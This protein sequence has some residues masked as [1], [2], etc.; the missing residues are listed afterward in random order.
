MEIL[1]NTPAGLRSILFSNKTLVKMNLTSLILAISVLQVCAAGSYAQTARLSL[2]MT[3]AR[4][5]EVLQDIE[6]QSEFFFLYSPR[7]I[8]VDRRISVKLKNQNIEEVLRKIFMDTDVE[9]V[10][11]G[12][13]IV[14]STEDLT[15]GDVTEL[16][17]A[18]AVPIRGTVRDAGGEAL[19]G[20]NIL[21]KGTGEGTVTDFDGNYQLDLETG[22][23]TLVFSYTGYQTMEVQVEGQS[24][25]DI[26]MVASIAELDEVVVVGY[27]TQRKKDLTG[28][29]GTIDGDMVAN[30]QNMQ[31]SQALQGSMA[32]VQVTRDNG[33]PGADA[34]IRIRGVTTIGDN[35]PLIIV[36]GIPF[37]NIDDVNPDDI[38][39]ISVLKDAASAAIYGSRAAAGV[40]LVT[41]KRAEA[42]QLNL[43]YNAE[44]GYDSPTDY[45]RKVDVVRYMQADNEMRWN[46]NGNT[47]TEYGTYPQEIVDNYPSLHADNPNLYPDVDMWDLVI[48]DRALRT[49]HALSLSAGTNVIRSKVSLAYDYDDGLYEKRKFER[50]SARFNND[51]TINDFISATADIFWRRSV[52]ND[53]DVNPIPHSIIHAPVYAAEWD[54][55][56]VAPGKA[57]AN[58][59]GQVKYGGFR[60][61]W[62]TSVGG[63]A[64]LTITPVEGLRFT[65]VVAPRFD[66][67]KGKHFRKKVEATSYSDPSVVEAVLQYASTTRLDEFRN[68]DLNVTTQF[69]AS[70]DKD[71]GDHHFNVMGG[72]ENFY[73][74]FEQQSASR[75]Q[76]DLNS[77]PYLNI[78]PLDL[79]DNSG[80]AWENA[81]RSWFGRI[82]YDYANKYYLQANVRFDGSSRFDSDYRWGSFPSFSAGWAISEEPFFEGFAG[83][84]FLKLRASWGTLGNERIGNYPY[85]STIDFSNAL[86]YQGSQVVSLQTAAQRQLAIRDISWETTESLDFGIDAVFFDNRVRLTADYFLKKTNDMLLALEIPDFIG[87]D[88]PD[89]NTG[90]MKTR[91]WELE[92]GYFKNEGI[93]RYSITANLSDYRSEMGDLGGTEFLGD[94]V[95][96]EGSEFDEWYGYIS[97][98][99]FQSQE[100]LDASAVTNQNVKV[101][102]VKYRDIS[103]PDGVPDGQIS[104]EYDRVLLG[105]SLPR[106]LYG[107]NFNMEFHN[108]DLSIAVQ[109]V[110]KQNTRMQS[111][112]VEPLAENWGNVPLFID[113]NY[114]SHYNSAEQNLAAQY[115]RLSFASRGN[116]YTMSDY[117]LFNG[118]Y[119]RLKNIT[120]GYSLPGQLLN[121]LRMQSARVYISG[122]DLFSIDMFPEGWDPEVGSSSY[123]ITRSLIMG[124]SVR[125]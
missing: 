80:T 116:N 5:E 85:Q 21:V 13:Q 47:G 91:G 94:Q 54:D 112:W 2:D 38:K 53:A 105:G 56:R 121:N 43:S 1:R 62:R 32:G 101:G 14:L 75:D 50:F 79:R 6:N 25:L 8:D 69:I 95:K 40:I 97:E 27:G 110:G 109:G 118:G 36:D 73:A 46:D 12:R 100:D 52:F 64:S 65:G 124:L 125:F 39:D 30:R 55:G 44:F 84:D 78:G 20:V 3:D 4:V 34:Q 113:G 98:G 104:P 86:L 72:Y 76:Y 15:Q 92:L 122:S 41:T 68:D 81:Y 29:V 57:G 51:I 48:K 18:A 60:D 11:K 111:R 58:I 7:I 17:A 71:M 24:T 99:L 83:M 31:V 123:P 63:K 87:F 33:A 37:D 45:P 93:F 106:F 89:Q 70:Y 88:N 10:I 28:A 42:G 61:D 120:L 9:Y 108:F 16:S 119:M 35:N 96:F 23:E 102:D 117:W 107:V 82:V 26:V 103:G 67:D 77:F 19:I 22:S 66:F 90:L 114:W 49:S 74:R 59:Y 115:P